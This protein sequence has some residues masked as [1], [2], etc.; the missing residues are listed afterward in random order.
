MIP[1]LK[2]SK[3][4]LKVEKVKEELK[5]DLELAKKYL[6]IISEIGGEKV[7]KSEDL[8]FLE[9]NSGILQMKLGEFGLG[10]GM[11]RRPFDLGT[12]ANFQY[13]ANFPTMYKQHATRDEAILCT[14]LIITFLSTYIKKINEKLEDE[15]GFKETITKSYKI[16]KLKL[17]KKIIIK[18]LFVVV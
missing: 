6:R 7:I 10:E 17:D 12:Y 3:K 1:I 8:E 16:K 2:K 15:E 13:I 9:L 14:S 11:F 18:L 5:K 4:N